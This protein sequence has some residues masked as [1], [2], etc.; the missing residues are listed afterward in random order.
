MTRRIG[1]V[2]NFAERS[3]L[4]HIGAHVAIGIMPTRECELCGEAAIRRCNLNNPLTT[5]SGAILA[6]W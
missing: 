5:V 4:L 3:S 2:V 6:S 1:L